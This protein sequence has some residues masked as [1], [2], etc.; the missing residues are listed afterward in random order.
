MADELE[1]VRKSLRE[2]D[3][4]LGGLPANPPPKA[5]HDLRTTSRRV[6]AVAAALA[7]DDR[8][9]S[10]RLLK[11]IEPVRKAAGEVRDMDVLISHARRMARKSA[12]ESLNRLVAHLESARKV[13]A[14]EFERILGQRRKAARDDLK[15][16][17]KMVKSALTPAKSSA[18]NAGQDGLPHEGVHAAA[19]SAVREL[20][21]WPRLD[22]GNIH[23]FRLKVK[24][25]RYVLQLFADADPSFIEALTDVQRGIGDWHDWQQL[26]EIARAILD[27]E[28]DSALLT[29]IDAITKRKLDRALASANALRGRHL[30]MPVAHGA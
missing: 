18:L 24:E 22:A 15:R 27:P 14:A 3:K 9:K 13:S 2:L 12:G 19:T 4:L 25:L 7:P 30:A 8:K 1:S 5:V 16:Y 20:G 17:S 21:E 6:Q 26:A 28:Q 11:T 29:R 23:A 10:R